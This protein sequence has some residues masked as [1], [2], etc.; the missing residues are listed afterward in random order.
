[1]F[2]P[3][4]TIQND[5]APYG[6]EPVVRHFNGYDIVYLSVEAN[7]QAARGEEAPYALSLSGGLG[8][9][10]AGERAIARYGRERVLFWF[11]DVLKEDEDLYRFLHDLM[12]RWGG[13]LY[14]FC[15][16]MRPE[17]VWEKH[18]IIPNNRMCPCS[19][20]LKVKFYREFILSMP[21]LP[22]VLIGY[23]AEELQRQERTCASYAQ[24][25][26]ASYVDYPLL[27]DPAEQRDLGIVCQQELGIA[28]PRVYALG[29]SYNNCGTDCCRAGIG[30][31][32]L[33]AIYFPVRFQQAM[34]W[35]E[36]M[37]ARGGALQGKAFCA[38]VESGTK[39]P[40]TLREIL[41]TYV[42]LAQAYLQAH[43][44]QPVS[45]KTLV[46]EMTRWQRKQQQQNQACSGMEA[47]FPM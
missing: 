31:R 21:R 19:Y 13:K 27:W 35:E 14:W 5:R 18:H 12:K 22:Q 37:R 4:Q 36:R 43:P 8:S 39:V 10:I 34:E 25:I 6:A 28:P 42:P 29:F 45:E 9:A 17:D 47:I 11:A 30:G 15:S 32:I 33:E 2:I 38:R 16:G 23:K 20:N 26:P 3:L 40:L 44:G 46:R 7:R 24:A 41:Q 1:M